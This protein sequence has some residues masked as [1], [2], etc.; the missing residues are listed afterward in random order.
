MTGCLTVCSDYRGLRAWRRRRQRR[1]QLHDGA[2]SFFPGM[3]TFLPSTPAA[4]TGTER[5]SVSLSFL[6]SAVAALADAHKQGR[7]KAKR[8]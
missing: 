3:G 8:I 7:I 6:V 5:A 2:G 1:R 4:A